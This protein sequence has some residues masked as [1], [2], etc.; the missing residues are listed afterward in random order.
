MSTVVT[1]EKFSSLQVVDDTVVNDMYADGDV[2]IVGDLSADN[3]TAETDITS[4]TGDIVVSAGDFVA[5]NGSVLLLDGGVNLLATTGGVTAPVDTVTQ[6]TS[7]TTGVTLNSRRGIVTTV[8][9]TLA[10]GVGAAFTVTNSEVAVGDLVLVNVVGYSGNPD[11]TTEG[12]PVVSVAAT[13]AG[14]FTV[15]LVNAHGA[16]ALN[17]TVQ[18]GFNVIKATVV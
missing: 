8:A 12:S 17:G 18:I 2:A 10:A 13:S 15:G 6:I 4:T 3:I 7:I 9:S 5:A 11:F 1:S 16:N 14:S